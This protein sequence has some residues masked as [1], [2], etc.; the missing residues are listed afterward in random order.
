MRLNPRHPVTYLW[1]LG[2]AYRLVGKREEALSVLQRAIA[3]NP[4]YLAAH[5]LVAA[6]FHELGRSEEARAEA[7]EVLRINPQYSLD[8]V[9]QRM[10]IK[11]PTALAHFI[12]ALE[13]AGLR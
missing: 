11:D 8:I 7:A 10:P 1:T 9:R 12:A 2:Q 13:G 6:V 5:M 4:D 3:R